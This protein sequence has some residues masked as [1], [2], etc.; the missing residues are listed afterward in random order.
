MRERSAAKP[1][2]GK[3]CTRAQPA[4]PASNG[5]LLAGRS[6]GT[7]CAPVDEDDALAEGTIFVFATPQTGETL[8]MSIRGGTPL[9]ISTSGT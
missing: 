6:C 8:A 3:H 7:Q 2:N 4:V 5:T 9:L 1:R